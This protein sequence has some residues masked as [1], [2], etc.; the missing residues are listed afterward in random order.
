MGHALD[1]VKKFIEGFNRHDKSVYEALSK[2]W[3]WQ[4]PGGLEPEGGWERGQNGLQIFMEAFSLRFE[5]SSFIE[6]TGEVAVEGIFTGKFQRPI[7]GRRP[8]G[9]DVNIPPTDK[10]VKV[11]ASIF[12]YINEKDL[13]Y[14][15]SFYWDNLLFFGQIGLRPEQLE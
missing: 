15:I 2:E 9:K 1:I 11:S 7:I 10:S 6:S 5:P 3:V 4:D 14:K 12:F 13:I 8:S